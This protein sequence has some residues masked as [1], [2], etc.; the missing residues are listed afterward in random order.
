MHASRDR[1][2]SHDPGERH[3]ASG[4]GAFVPRGEVDVLRL[5]L[6]DGCLVSDAADSDG[7]LFP[8]HKSRLFA[9]SSDAFFWNEWPMELVFNRNKCGRVDGVGVRYPKGQVAYRGR[10]RS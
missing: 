6:E 2:R 9:M 1:E 4:D 8:M 7:E 3:P 5:W 10:R